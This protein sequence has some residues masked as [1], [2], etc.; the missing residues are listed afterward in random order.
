MSSSESTAVLREQK[1]SK[2]PRDQVPLTPPSISFPLS[3]DHLLHLVQYNV[4]R[5]FVSNKR[6]LN[7]LLT[8][9]T[10]KPSSPTTCPIGGPYRDDTMVY[11]LNPNI[12][13]SLVPTRL[14][15]SRLHSLWINLIPFPRVR[16]NLI[17]REGSFDHW[18]LLQD[19]IGELMNFTPP[20]EQ[21]TTA[22]SFTVGDPE[23]RI[24]SLL[25]P[26]RDGDE[27][28][29]G[30]NGLLVWGEPYDMQSW[31]ATPSFLAKW[32]W[33]VEGCTELVECSN[34]W[35]LKRGEEPIH[36]RT[37]MIQPLAWVE[38]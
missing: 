10:E 28:T 37:P 17:R 14:Q 13:F 6:T 5:A 1:P 19:L 7:V 23:P 12:P 24:A 20:R 38:S 33:A 4:F 11:P 15:Q 8:G 9:W 32:S 34:R 18:E 31:E 27:I 30:R 3:T 36:L 22:Y 25:A 2:P 26:E 16:D 35:R 21:R 29:A